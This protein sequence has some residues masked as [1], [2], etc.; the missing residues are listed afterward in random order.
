VVTDTGSNIKAAVRLMD[1]LHL[2]CIAHKPN[3]V[4]ENALKL[5]GHEEIYIN[6]DI[7]ESGLNTYL[8]SVGTW[9]VFLNVVKLETECWLKNKNSLDVKQC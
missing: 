4:I 8:R 1:L 3:L 2:P 6:D 7:D 5:S 9:L